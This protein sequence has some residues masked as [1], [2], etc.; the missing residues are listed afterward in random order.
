[1]CAPLAIMAAISIA[2]SLAAH[3]SAAM[4][5]LLLGHLQEKRDVVLEQ[6]RREGDVPVSGAAR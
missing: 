3:D 6:L 1:M 2:S 5:E 4:R